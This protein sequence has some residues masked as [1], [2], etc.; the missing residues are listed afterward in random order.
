MEKEYNFFE[1]IIIVYR[2]K[3]PLIYLKKYEQIVLKDV[4]SLYRECFVVGPELALHFCYR[5]P[6][7]YNSERFGAAEVW[8]T[9]CSHTI[10]AAA[11]PNI[12]SPR[13]H[14]KFR[15]STTSPSISGSFDPC[16]L[17]SYNHNSAL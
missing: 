9:V 16:I 2:K 10:M 13:I 15:C 6:C 8:R 5:N 3:Y 7:R 11:D 14:Y 4:N 1:S 17:G 12:R